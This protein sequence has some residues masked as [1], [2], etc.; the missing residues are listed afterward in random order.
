[1]MGNDKQIV[2]GLWIG[3]ELS[4][5]E[6]MSINSFLK[7]GYTYHLYTYDK[8]KGIPEGTIVKDANTII[9]KSEVFSYKNGSMSGISNRFRF[10]M[11]YKSNIPWVDTDLICVKYY[12]FSN[13]KYIIMSE[14]N[15]NYNKDIICAGI[16]KFPEKDPMLVEAI[17]LCVTKKKDI[18]EGKIVW[19]VGPSTMKY[20]VETYNM[21]EYVK[22]WYFATSCAC[23]HFYSLINPNFEVNCVDPNSK[24]I[25]SRRMSELPEGTHFIHLWNEF[26]RRGN[27]DKNGTFP[28]NTLYE[29]LKLEYLNI[30]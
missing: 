12:D 1:M 8:V 7:H 5:L 11:M 27:I 6:K 14:S 26:W 22:P 28:E 21:Q 20:L 23:S 30:H 9:D 16:L 17:E 24:I 4:N 25:Y 19:G 10:E 3:P 15:I 2:G 13:D 29:D 18:I